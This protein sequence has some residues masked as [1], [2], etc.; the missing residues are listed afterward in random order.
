M[1]A[2]APRGNVMVR[3]LLRLAATAL[4]IRSA[5]FLI[6][7]AT[8]GA[9]GVAVSSLS[10]SLLYGLAHLPLPLASGAASELAIV[11]NY[12]LN[13]RWTFTGSLPSWTRFAKFNSAAVA[14]LGVTVLCAWGLVRYLGIQY[15]AANLLALLASGPL[16]FG[17]NVRW[18]WGRSAR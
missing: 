18:V 7:F 3:P 8:A 1:T 5:W 15:L 12:L 10:L 17:V 14:G 11:T 9:A 6:R 2:R 4:S 16:S 13:E